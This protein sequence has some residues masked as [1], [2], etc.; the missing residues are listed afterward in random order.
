MRS[1]RAIR[2]AEAACRDA[3]GW[4]V[5][6]LDALC[7]RLRGAL[8]LRYKAL[9]RNVGADARGCMAD[10]ASILTAALELVRIGSGAAFYI[11]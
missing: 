10:M 3:A 7:W 1:R 9:M 5:G 11:A 6:Q 2:P 4:Q 8:M